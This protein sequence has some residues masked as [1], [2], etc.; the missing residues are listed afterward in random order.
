MPNMLWQA[1]WMRCAMVQCTDQEANSEISSPATVRPD[2]RCHGDSRSAQMDNVA[3]VRNIAQG[4]TPV[5]ILLRSPYPRVSRPP[6]IGSA[7]LHTSRPYATCLGTLT[8]PPWLT[9]A[10]PVVAGELATVIATNRVCQWPPL[11]PAAARLPQ[12]HRPPLWEPI[13]CWPRLLR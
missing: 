12:I 8:S 5:T 9:L 6:W 3:G 4:W 13:N 1:D 10:R 11:S 2:S 7:E